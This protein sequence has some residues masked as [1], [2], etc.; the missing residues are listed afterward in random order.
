MAGSPPYMAPE[1]LM[2]EVVD[3]RSDIYG[4]GAV[5]YEMV[6]GRRP[7]A[8]S[9]GPRLVDAVLHAPPVPPQ[10]LNTRLSPGLEAI[11]LKCLDKDPSRRYQ[12]ARELL[13]DLERLSVPMSPVTRPQPRVQRHHAGWASLSVAAVTA[14]LIGTGPVARGFLGNGLE[15]AT[16]RSLVV[17]PLE[18]LSGTRARSSSRTA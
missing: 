2:G 7:F 3:A 5:L 15:G 17:L 18:N 13:V 12:S 6:T 16:V 14:V 4:A 11:V 10:D 9:H 8:E 1:Q